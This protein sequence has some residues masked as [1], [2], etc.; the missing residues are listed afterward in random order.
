MQ[1]YYCKNKFDVLAPLSI[2]LCLVRYV[3]ANCTRAH[4]HRPESDVSKLTDNLTDTIAG[5]AF[6]VGYR[7]SEEMAARPGPVWPTD[8]WQRELR[9]IVRAKVH[10]VLCDYFLGQFVP[11]PYHIAPDG[12]SITCIRCGSTSYNLNDVHNHYCGA[13][14]VTYDT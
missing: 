8:A 2:D 14:R 7:V 11:K 5:I 4:C 10:S 1:C 9:R 3:C 12:T 13:C 6:E